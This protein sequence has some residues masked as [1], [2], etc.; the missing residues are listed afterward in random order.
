MYTD[1]STAQVEHQH[2]LELEPNQE[3]I[4]QMKV[5]DG[6]LVVDHLLFTDSDLSRNL[7]CNY[8]TVLLGAESTC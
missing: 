7:I 8:H 5:V 3:P 6:R 1:T 4:V 2:P